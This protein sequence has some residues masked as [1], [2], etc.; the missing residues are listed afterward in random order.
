MIQE[1]ITLQ[2][3]EALTE[4]AVQVQ[5]RGRELEDKFHS[6]AEAVEG[7]HTT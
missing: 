4:M 2:S 5:A 6:L 7:A 3:L 1:E